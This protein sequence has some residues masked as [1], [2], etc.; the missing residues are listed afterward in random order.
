MAECGSY[1]HH[2]QSTGSAMSLTA[3]QLVSTRDTCEA[4]LQETPACHCACLDAGDSAPF[5]LPGYQG[6]AHA[7]AHT[8]LGMACT[9]ACITKQRDFCVCFP[10]PV[11]LPTSSRSWFQNVEGLDKSSRK[12]LRP[13]NTQLPSADP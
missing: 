2:L 6:D 13:G 1:L 11:L 9:A 5:R 8:P 3:Q 7:R 12:M 10:T 4:H